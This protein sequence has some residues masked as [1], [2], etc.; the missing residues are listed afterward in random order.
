MAYLQPNEHVL[1]GGGITVT[2]IT[3]GFTDTPRWLTRMP[4]N[5]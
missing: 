4:S 3:N 2:Y 5:P 1:T